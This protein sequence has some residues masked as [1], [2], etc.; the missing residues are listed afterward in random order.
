MKGSPWMIEEVGFTGTRR[1]MTD[2]QKLTVENILIV[3]KPTKSHHGMCIGADKD[4]DDIC[5]RLEIHRRG[6]PGVD[7]AGNC[8]TRACCHGIE[9]IMGER[10]YVVRDRLIVAHTPILIATPKTYSKES[11]SG[12]WVTIGIA[13]ELG[14]T[15]YIVFPDGTISDKER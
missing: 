13:R 6:W 4:F 1:G 11:R 12:T 5:K 2:L 8:N 9:E 7:K 3:L 10:H 14:A 15:R